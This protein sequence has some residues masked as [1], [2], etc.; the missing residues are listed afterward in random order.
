M[1][2]V[3]LVVIIFSTISCT[4]KNQ[5]SLVFSSENKPSVSVTLNS[6]QLFT[7]NSVVDVNLVS[8]KSLIEMSVVVGE[9]CQDIWEDFKPIKTINL[10]SSEGVQKVSVK[11]RNVDGFESDCIQKSIT[12]D[13]T[14]PE[15]VG[16]L[17]LSA[18]RSQL[19][20]SP[21]LVLPNVTDKFSGIELQSTRSSL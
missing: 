6:G 19:T 3:F 7:K 5:V 14:P 16:S 8:E 9:R 2:W 1:Y 4:T 11:V 17:S 13:L 20:Q 12:L 15:L 10:T 18:L 21:N